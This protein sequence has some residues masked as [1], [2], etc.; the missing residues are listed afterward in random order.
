MPAWILNFV[1]LV[2][3]ASPFWQTK[4]PNQWSEQEL[5]QLLTDSPWSQMAEATGKA[6]GP[7]VRA[8]FATAPVME[9]A[10]QERLRRAQLRSPKNS[11]AAPSEPDPLVEEYREWLEANRSAQI[12]VALS[13]PNLTA[14]SEEREVRRMEEESYLAIGRKKIKMT[15]HFA[16]SSGD[17]YLRLVFPREVRPTDKSIVLQLYLPGVAIPY[18]Q[19]EFAVKEMIVNGKLEL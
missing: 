4:P 8:F 3:F 14:F 17:P 7:P 18:R 10:E 5:Q 19:A 1:A 2:C 11:K 6:A 12:V 16:P 15:G 9:Q 13:I